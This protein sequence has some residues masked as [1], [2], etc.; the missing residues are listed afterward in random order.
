MTTDASPERRLH[1]YLQHVRFDPGLAAEHE[2]RLFI[3]QGGLPR[4][5]QHAGP[6]SGA[7]A[8]AADG[9]EAAPES[10]ALAAD[11]IARPDSSLQLDELNR[12]ESWAR[13][14]LGDY[15][16]RQ[17]RELALASLDADHAYA[18]L[19]RRAALVDALHR[20]AFNVAL[21]DLPALVALR[22]ESAQRELAHKRQNL[23]VKRE[24]LDHLNA[25]LPHLPD[26]DM[27]KAERDYFVS[28]LA[29]VRE[30][31]Q[32]CAAD[33][34]RLEALLPDLTGFRADPEFVLGHLV[35][36][37]RGGY[38]RAELSFGS[39]IDTGYCVDS[40]R[41]RPGQVEILKELIVRIETLLQSA[42]LE[43]AHQYFE[44]DEDLSRFT[45][46]ETMHTIPSVLEARAL[47]G[48][49]ALLDELRSA[50]RAILPLERYLI[51][52]VEDFEGAAV[53]SL[54]SM[55]LK[56]D[57]GG[58]RT[59]QIP[60]WILGVLQDAS[61]FSTV[62]LLELAREQ[63]LLSL[64]EVARLVQALE[65]LNE[66]RNFVGAAE[67]YYYD[68][69]ARDNHCYVDEFPENRINDALGRLYLFK[70]HRFATVDQFD[71]Y[72]LWLVDEVQSLTK[73]LLARALD[74][75]HVH[76]LGT[77]PISV[78]LGRKEI[79]AIDTIR[80]EQGGAL[81]ERLKDADQVL[82]LFEYIAATDYD[83][84]GAL[85]DA[86]AEVVRS[87]A[88]GP[89]EGKEQGR[90][91][92]RS[93]E[94]AAPGHTARWTGILLGRYAHLAM[95]TLISIR[96]PLA[97][98]VETLMGRFL[99]EFNRMPF[100][101][102]NVQALAMPLHQHALRSLALGQKGLEA[103]KEFHPELHARLGNSEILALKWSLLLHAVCALEGPNDR[104]ERSAELAADMLTR[105]GYQDQGLLGL[106]RLLVQHHRSLAGLAKTAAYGDQA[107][108][109]YFEIAD[110]KIVNV[111]LLYLINEAVLKAA[112]G[113]F[114]G[115]TLAVRRLFD[116][117][118]RILAELRG[119]PTKDQ[120][121]ELI[122]IY[123]DEKKAELLAETRLYLLLLRS[124]AVGVR[125]AVL[126]PLERLNAKEFQKLSARAPDLN[127]LHKEIVLGNRR[128][129]EQERLGVKFVQSLK[130][131]LSEETIL[132]L[133]QDQTTAFTWFFA[134]FPNR[135]LLSRTPQELAAQVRQ[136]S[137]FR[138]AR[139]LVDVVPAAEGS[140]DGLLIY[141][142]GF[143]RSH[144]RVAYA[145]SRK[146]VNIVLGKV[147]R[148]SYGPEDFGYCYYFQIS[149]PPPDQPLVARDLEFL[150]Q[151]ETPP[152]LEHPTPSGAFRRRSVRVEFLPDDGK[153]YEIQPSGD[154][155]QRMPVAYS[156]V[157]VVMRDQPFLFFKVS[158][159]FDLHQAE[160]QQ[161]LI[162]TT[163]NQVQDT[164]YLPPEDLVR[165]RGSNFE[166]FLI[167]RVHSDL[168]ASVL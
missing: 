101:L 148:I 76:Q 79:V 5:S 119:F 117:A 158:Q 85:K 134:G 118:S 156:R 60:L 152:R 165:L 146:R 65:F 138:T 78:H 15:Y 164:F 53:P 72:R 136:F 154:A 3:L 7:A 62:A 135:Y 44:V 70:K 110:R 103:L 107:L 24:R 106:V 35:L 75:T 145:L 147:N 131:F 82:A 19:F 111:V 59:I 11:S 64:Y 104:P 28:I 56:E 91:A 20:F 12:R 161:A 81:A 127:S 22:I 98:G 162:S 89:A 168:M 144:S 13:K 6:A 100:L 93:A 159:V 108:A 122:N 128:P 8:S 83:L 151:T 4:L 113:R 143:S 115:D 141:T 112:G 140:G 55:N 47:V 116:E 137:S 74:R 45:T 129:G 121:L 133:T 132:A 26:E 21:E 120:S 41:L 155:Y 49:A 63:G 160:V 57:F 34:E 94:N 166:E 36:F 163:G 126:E 40:R 96:D 48:S 71:S 67:A 73:A 25:Q 99:P 2:E 139:V 109:Q 66:L 95:G 27:S 17:T 92:P 54:T 50:F 51:G 77:C 52:K 90:A 149:P 32:A 150:I 157:R 123:F 61:D 87:L 68:Q 42:G 43:T 39:D 23:P 46:P 31:A 80:R 86:M 30:D 14:A 38:G 9:S 37:A 102:R 58:L 18:I 16:S 124:H 167:D 33:I 114:E 142:H 97:A 130:Q 1:D 29:S 84:S 10:A 88:P 105:L 125:E 153:G 69:E